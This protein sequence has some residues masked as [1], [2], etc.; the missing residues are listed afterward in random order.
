MS[1]SEDDLAKFDTDTMTAEQVQELTVCVRR[2]SKTVCVRQLS[3]KFMSDELGELKKGIDHTRKVSRGDDTLAKLNALVLFTR[4]TRTLF[5]EW[6]DDP[7]GTPFERSMELLCELGLV[8][9]WEGP[10]SEA[11][12]PATRIMPPNDATPW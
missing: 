9:R 10:I 1:V 7:I 6:V 2:L 12:N 4:L 11:I 5:G 3:N 8:R